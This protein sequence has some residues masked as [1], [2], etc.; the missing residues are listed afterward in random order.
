MIRVMFEESFTRAQC[1]ILIDKATKETMEAGHGNCQQL[2]VDSRTD[3]ERNSGEAN[4]NNV[5][6][7]ECDGSFGE[8]NECS[9]DAASCGIGTRHRYFKII[10]GGVNIGCPYHGDYKEIETC[11]VHCP[12]TEE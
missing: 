7:D 9:T 8:W 2:L 4:P 6:T 12:S 1:Q 3:E 5:I 11:V 10:T